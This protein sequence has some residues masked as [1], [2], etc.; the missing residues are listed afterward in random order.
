[1]RVVPQPLRRSL[2]SPVFR[3]ISSFIISSGTSSWY[4][5]GIR[6]SIGSATSRVHVVLGFAYFSKVITTFPF[7]DPVSTYL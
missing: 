6:F 7:F 1:M 3:N 2:A 4:P 5:F